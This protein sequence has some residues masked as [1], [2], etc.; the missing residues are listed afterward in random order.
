MEEDRHGEGTAERGGPASP[1]SEL[2]CDQEAWSLAPGLLASSVLAGGEAA[3]LTGMQYL[4]IWVW[5][6]LVL[7]LNHDFLEALCG[8]SN[9]TVIVLHTHLIDVC[10]ALC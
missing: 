9:F 8:F 10:R 7:L 4:W 3:M 6:A 2:P 5:A 1:L